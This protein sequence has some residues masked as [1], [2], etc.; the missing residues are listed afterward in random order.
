MRLIIKL[1]IL[2]FFINTA[3]FAEIIKE[4]EILGNKRI[5]KKTIILF[6]KI[7]ID[8]NI[9]E[10][11]LNQIIKELYSTNFFKDVK[12]SLVDQTLK[13]TVEENPVIQ[14]LIFNGIKKKNIIST[15]K[16][17]LELKEKHPFLKNTVKSDENKIINILRSNGYYFS[18]VESEIKNNDNYTVDLIYNIDLGKKAHINKIKFIGDKKIKDGKLKNIIVSEESKFWKFIS[19]KKFLDINR[20]SLDE[21]LLRSYYKNRGYYNVKIESSSAQVI[22]NDNFE[23][24]FNINAGKKYYFNNLNLNFPSDFSEDEFSK[25]ISALNKLKGE[26]YSLKKINS[27]LKEINNLLL[28]SDYAFFN[29][30]Y[31]ENLYDNKLDLTINLTESEKKY[32]EKINLFGN[33]ITNDKVLRN[34]LQ[35]DEGDPYNEILL[36]NSI[37]EI[38]SLGIF[39]NVNSKT[40]GGKS[41]KL[42][43][44]DI[45][46]EE[47]PTGEIMAGAGTGTSGSSITFGIKEKNYL[48]EG[49]KLDVNLTLS[50]SSLTGLFSTTTKNY[51]NSNKDLNTSIE[52]SSFDRMSSFGYKTTKTGFSLGTSY[53]QYKDIYFSPSFSNYYETMKTSSS[54]SNTRKKQEGDYFDSTFN[55]RFT[56][57][58]LNQNFRPS[59]GYK[60]GFYQSI[61][62]YSDDLTIINQIDYAKYYTFLDDQ[63][64]EVNFLLKTANSISGEDIRVSKRLF[65]PSR[66]L[67]GFE[68][69]KVGP[70]DSGD[71]IGGNYSSTLNL[72]TNLPK[73]LPEVQNLDFKLF[74]DAANLWGVDFNSSL[75]NSKIRSSTGLAVDWFT[76]IGPLNFS[77]AKPITKA[78][79]DVEQ[80][81]RFDIG[82][83]F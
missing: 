20:I 56:L 83:T 26:I 71:F 81:F 36:N 60:L 28:V 79:S 66:R 76:P 46:V 47:M 29:A 53:E 69:G 16:S 24:I 22:D 11:N 78:S 31:N 70:I 57:N 19:N 34:Q 73:F 64:F 37:N 10:S 9:N 33:Y 27:I 58:K 25:I 52:N 55:Y 23:L 50:D 4:F 21:N 80:T 35:V 3:S 44:I 32:V 54:A 41:E 43:I 72:S 12:V 30:T 6:S 74:L 65:I 17:N 63:V 59:G 62:L 75:D 39:K 7:K 2:I 18:S 45:T 49:K 51:N 68:S 48:G 42:N 82:T 5:S 38:K 61:P 40:Y 13:I 77:F 1:L 14:S 15:L 8:E 67:R